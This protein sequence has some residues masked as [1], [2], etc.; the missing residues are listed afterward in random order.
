MA[1]KDQIACDC[2]RSRIKR[3]HFKRQFDVLMQHT[4]IE[5]ERARAREM[6]KHVREVRKS[7]Q[8]AIVFMSLFSAS[9]ANDASTQS[10]F[11]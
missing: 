7:N 6:A 10:L 3:R 5:A 4:D 8:C 2:F 11:R 9:F 1:T